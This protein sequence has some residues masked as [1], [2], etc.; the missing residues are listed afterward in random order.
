MSDMK[1]ASRSKRLRRFLFGGIALA[2][3][4][5]VAYFVW[6]R[7]DGIRDTAFEYAFLLLT[8]GM[9]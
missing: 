1:S 8:L 6:G 4:A 3:V 5:L 9:K 7:Y 2:L